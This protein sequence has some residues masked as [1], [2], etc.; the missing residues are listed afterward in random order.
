MRYAIYFTPPA[1]HPLSIAAARW[2]GRDCYGQ[3]RLSAPAG[4][5]ALIAD[6]ARY[7][8]HATLKAPFRLD[9]DEC[10][11]HL[12]EAIEIYARRTAPVDLARVEIGLIEGF[13]ALLAPDPGPRL[14]DLA[15][16]IVTAFDEFRAPLTPEE[17][18]RRRPESLSERQRENLALWGYPH[19]LDDF[20]FHMTLTGRIAPAERAAVA[21]ALS[22]HFARFDGRPLTID[23]IALFVQP[24]P[25]A[26][27]AVHS[28][29][30]LLGQHRRLT[31]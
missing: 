8:F 20:R 3:Q 28:T 1:D 19:V 16:D 14:A 18:A 13:F 22:H 23:Q 24:D 21:A 6:P 15:D 30:A 17:I 11:E 26:P 7:G 10:E 5:Q 29:H 27:F 2:L 12:V 25:E 4:R 9:E 31:A